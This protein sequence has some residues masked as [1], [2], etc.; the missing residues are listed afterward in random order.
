LKLK[1]LVLILITTIVIVV[2]DSNEMLGI[3]QIIEVDAHFLQYTCG[4]NNIDMRV[5][6]VRDSGFAYLQGKVISPELILNQKE[7]AKLVNQKTA[8]FR[9]GREP[10]LSDFTLV[11]YVKESNVK[12]CSGAICFKIKQIKYAGDSTFTT[13]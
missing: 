13:F 1:V 2:L 7:L 11:G 6:L 5:T 3:K 10:T 12:H 9:E 8:A 4:K